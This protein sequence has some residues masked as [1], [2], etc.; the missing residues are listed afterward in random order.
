MTSFVSLVDAQERLE[1]VFTL[2][3]NGQID[4]L[5]AAICAKYLS[6][7]ILI[8]VFGEL[9]HDDLRLINHSNTKLQLSTMTYLGALWYRRS[10]T[11]TTAEAALSIAF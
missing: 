7:M 6:E 4:F 10:P 8:N 3:I 1:F 11:S 2:R 9:F 5:N